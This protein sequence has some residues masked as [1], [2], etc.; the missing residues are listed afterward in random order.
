ML[1][2]LTPGSSFSRCSALRTALLGFML[3]GCSGQP[4]AAQVARL[5]VRELLP[6]APLYVEGSVSS[7][8]VQATQ[9]GDA[10]FDGRVTNGIEARG[11]DN[12]LDRRVEPG[13]Y[14]VISYQRACQ[15]TCAYLDPPTDRCEAT[16]LVHAVLSLTAT[17]VPLQRGGCVFRLAAN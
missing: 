16:M 11:E 13:E 4:E 5:V 6:P 3:A 1:H 8:K 10:V 15:G 12:V 2:W 9:D 14:R 7:L 17:V